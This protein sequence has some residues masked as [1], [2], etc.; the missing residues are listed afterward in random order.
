MLAGF[1]AIAAAA[2]P[3]V[4]PARAPLA[5]A[6]ARL[7]KQEQRWTCV[8]LSKE[9]HSNEYIARRTGLNPHTVA[10][11]IKRYT[12]T[13]NPGSGSRSGRPRATTE[14][15]DTHIALTSRVQPFSP[16]R[17]IRRALN[18]DISPKTVARRLDEAG[19]VGRV[20][21]RKPLLNAATIRKR[22]SFAEGYSEMYWSQVLFSDEKIFWGDGFCG[23]TWVRR[24]VGEAFNPVYVMKKTAHPVKVNVWACFSAAGRGAIAIF[25]ENCNAK[26]MKEILVKH[27]FKAADR[28]FDPTKQWFLLHDNGSNHNNALVK[29]WLDSKSVR[30]IDFPPYSPDLNPIENLWAAL[31]R[32]VEKT[33]CSTQDELIACVKAVWLSESKSLME[34]LIASMPRRIQAVLD[35]NGAHTKY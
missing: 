26:M 30:C 28:L 14:E 35:A 3:A 22:I 11:V 13:G 21:R 1:A 27:L 16:P 4:A 10:A 15:Q 31:A 6:A 25:K 5:R 17:A 33:P 29:E 23:Q 7:L 34:R 18:L 19:L 20:A 8:A 12:A 2:S 9:G 32:E 24:P